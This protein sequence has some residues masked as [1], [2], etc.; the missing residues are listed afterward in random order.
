MAAASQFQLQAW[1]GYKLKPINNKNVKL[2]FGLGYRFGDAGEI[3]AGIDWGDLKVALGYDL[4]L[5]D[6]SDVNNRNGGFEI[7]ANY[8]I[9]IYKKPVVNPAVICPK[10]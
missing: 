4:T 8:I 9:K 7:A 1:G 6:L 5:S 3:L 2:L 10:L